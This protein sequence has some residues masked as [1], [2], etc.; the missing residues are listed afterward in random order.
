MSPLCPPGWARTAGS[1]G[2]TLQAAKA[3]GCAGHGDGDDGNKGANKAARG[4]CGRGAPSRR[5]RLPWRPQ[6]GFPKVFPEE[7]AHTCPAAPLIPTG[8]AHR[9]VGI[10]FFLI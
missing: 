1:P 6:R 7:K 5:R 10:G 4:Q 8:S 2:C 3:T 9:D